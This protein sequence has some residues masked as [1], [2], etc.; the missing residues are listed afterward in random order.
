MLAITAI[1]AI[2]AIPGHRS[3]EAAQ[4]SGRAG[5]LRLPPGPKGSFFLGSLPEMSQGLLQFYRRCAKE[6]GDVVRFRM[7][8]VPVYFLAHPRD[9][10]YVLVKNQANFTK[11]ADYRALRRV[12]GNGLLTSEGD[13]WRRQRS[14]IQPAFHRESIL[15]YAK[16]MTSVTTHM[17]ETWR[18]GEQRD[19]HRDMMRL[20]LEIVAQCL[21]SVEVS[22]SADRVGEAL[23]VVTAAFIKSAGRALLF[24][25][26]IPD[27][28]AGRERRAIRELNRIVAGIIQQRRSSGERH[29]DLLDTLLHARDLEGSPMSDTQLRDEV[30]TLF[31]A[32]HET[33]ALA[34][35]WAGYLL[36]LNPQVESLLLEELRSVLGDR[37]PTLEDL[38]QL[39]YTEMVIK[40]AM[41]LYPPVWGMGRRAIA[42]CEIGGYRIKAGSTCLFCHG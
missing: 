16:V 41:R 26:H 5:S 9:I 3:F 34:L 17:L 15:Q 31:L 21:Y 37:I 36:A 18:E 6:Y 32:G 1:L 42:D 27:P 2:M 14:L 20:T 8:Y 12:V 28:F 22:G 30:M 7:A 23:Q 39:R 35:S 19:L 33:T 40:E 25:F 11:S 13:F 10:E 29:N 38:P 4:T 24:P